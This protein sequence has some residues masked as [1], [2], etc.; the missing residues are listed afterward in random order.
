MPELHELIGADAL[1]RLTESL[2]KLTLI[3]EEDQDVTLQE[4][5]PSEAATVPPQRSQPHAGP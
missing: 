1:A 4:A 2:G 3:G 5:E